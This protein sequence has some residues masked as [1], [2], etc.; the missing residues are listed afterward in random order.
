[1]TGGVKAHGLGFDTIMNFIEQCWYIAVEDLALNCLWRSDIP[2][3]SWDFYNF[4]LSFRSHCNT[5]DEEQI[6]CA[7]PNTVPTTLVVSALHCLLFVSVSELLTGGYCSA[8]KCFQ[9][10]FMYRNISYLS[11]YFTKSSFQFSCC[12]IFSIVSLI[13][14]FFFF[15]V[16]QQLY[17]ELHGAHQ[18][19][20]KL[21]FGGNVSKLQLRVCAQG[22]NL[23]TC[24]NA[25]HPAL[26]LGFPSQPWQPCPGLSQKAGCSSVHLSPGVGVWHNVDLGGPSIGAVH[27][28]PL[29]LPCCSKHLLSH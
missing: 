13:W 25:T 8:L 24:H 6:T 19:C 15:F 14:G 28:E 26:W 20:Q 12:T 22:D 21:V 2:C 16:W 3:D 11:L 9:S 10:M 18:F 7:L 27:W 23:P 29:V 1:M 5:C 17:M 4:I